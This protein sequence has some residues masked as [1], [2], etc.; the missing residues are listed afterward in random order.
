MG[1]KGLGQLLGE[2]CSAATWGKDCELVPLRR[3][4]GHRVA[5]DG[6]NT[7]HPYVVVAYDVHVKRDA[8]RIPDHDEVMTTA[9]AMYAAQVLAKYVRHGVTPIFVDDGVATRLKSETQKS[10][11]K[12]TDRYADQQ[13]DAEIRL[14][15][16]EE[17]QAVPRAEPRD[18]D[19]RL[20]RAEQQLVV[21]SEK[22]ELKK[23]V[24]TA[25]KASVRIG[26]KDKALLRATV[27]AM[28]IP[29]VRAPA[30]AEKYCAQ[31]VR[32]GHALAAHSNDT[33]LL[34]HGCP[35]VINKIEGDAA[36]VVFLHNVLVQLELTMSQ[37]VDLCVMCGTDYNPNVPGF[38]PVRC[39]ALIRR[40]GS[41]DAMPEPA[42]AT[43]ISARANLPPYHK[44]MLRNEAE[45]KDWREV[46]REF[47]EGR[48]DIDV[49][50]LQ[51]DECDMPRVRALV[52]QPDAMRDYCEAHSK[53]LEA[54]EHRVPFVLG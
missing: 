10:R 31:L 23:R 49:E 26:E 35:V 33:D 30:E 37:F 3:M 53:L 36:R 52:G 42:D 27:T 9:R 17:A 25:I 28:G 14:T 20:R 41:L 1:I 22:A 34:A 29:C 39:Y 5:I 12:Q 43:F 50:V 15:K 2:K 16:L 8:E 13:V 38:G 48:Y 51:V 32:E 21:D 18:E 54:T 24:V 45:D 7:F 11:R 19:E 40:Y 47:A 4:A 46:R 44:S 6:P